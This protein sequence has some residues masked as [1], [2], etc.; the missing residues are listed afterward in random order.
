MCGIRGGYCV[1][2]VEFATAALERDLRRV[3]NERLV[4]VRMRGLWGEIDERGLGAIRGK[5]V[6]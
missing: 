6:I 4:G 2:R 5:C 3:S 1:S